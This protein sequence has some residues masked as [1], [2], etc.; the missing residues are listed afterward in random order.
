MPLIK[1]IKSKPSYKRRLSNSEDSNYT[2]GDESLTSGGNHVAKVAVGRE[3][4]NVSS[5]QE[6]LNEAGENKINF[7]SIPLFHP[8]FRRDYS[9]IIPR[10]SSIQ[11][12][13]MLRNGPITRSDM[14]IT[15]DDWISS[16]TGKISEWINVSSFC[17]AINKS[18]EL[19][20]KQEYL[21]AAHLGFIMI[22]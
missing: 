15:N 2:V 22:V 6:A 4:D 11:P 14:C 8:R 13:T 5:I 16:V 12:L 1:W 10:L 18:G 7:L 21:F 9:T 19:A 3:L 17:T 20:L